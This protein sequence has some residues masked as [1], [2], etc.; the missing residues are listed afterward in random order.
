M[1]EQITSDKPSNIQI[2][3]HNKL[4]KSPARI[5]EKFQKSEIEPME[6]QTL[7]K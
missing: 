2:V 7:G 1:V 5:H 3:N 6:F 4:D